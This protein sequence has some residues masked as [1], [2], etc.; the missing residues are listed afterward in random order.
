MD[1]GGL[2]LLL[3]E[4]KVSRMDGGSAAIDRKRRNTHKL[5]FGKP[6]CLKYP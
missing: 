1:M 4:Q 3:I 5:F 6:T 2:I